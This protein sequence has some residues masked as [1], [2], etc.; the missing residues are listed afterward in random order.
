MNPSACHQRWELAASTQTLLRLLQCGCCL[1]PIIMRSFCVLLSAGGGSLSSRDPYVM[2]SKLLTSK[3]KTKIS[4]SQ[5]LI[6]S[7]KTACAW[8]TPMWPALQFCYC[9][10]KLSLQWINTCLAFLS[11]FLSFFLWLE[12][13]SH[14]FFFLFFVCFCFVLFCLLAKN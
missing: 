12:K 9:F 14:M 13:M 10:D 4:I 3:T 2:S 11:F 6:F 1:P 5:S 7:H 8:L